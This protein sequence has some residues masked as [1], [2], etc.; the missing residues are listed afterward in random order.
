MELRS[1][2]AQLVY[3][4]NFNRTGLQPRGHAPSILSLKR[5][6]RLLHKRRKVWV[7]ACMEGYPEKGLFLLFLHSHN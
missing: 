3:D 4:R 5:L 2:R 1:R 7:F 6:R